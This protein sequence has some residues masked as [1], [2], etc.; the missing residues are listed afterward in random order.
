MNNFKDNKNLIFLTGTV[1]YLYLYSSL[2]NKNYDIIFIYFTI[3]FAGYFIVGSKI[4]IYN[5]LIILFDILNKKFIIREGNYDKKFEQGK[6]KAK[7][8]K[9]FN[10]DG[11]SKKFGD[12]SEDDGEELIDKMDEKDQDNQKKKEAGQVDLKNDPNKNN[13]TSSSLLEQNLR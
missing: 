2:L 3:L 6:Q 1:S 11:N 12:M 10:K 8:N 5:L 7:K 13:A 9:R 4:F